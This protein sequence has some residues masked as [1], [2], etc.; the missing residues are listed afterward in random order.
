MQSPSGG[1]GWRSRVARSITSRRRRTGRLRYRILRRR[2]LAVNLCGTSRRCCWH[3]S[4]PR[5]GATAC[6][7][8]GC[9]ERHYAAP[10]F[11][12]SGQR[13]FSTQISTQRGSAVESKCHFSW[14]KAA[15]RTGWPGCDI[16]LPSWSC[17]FDSRRPLHRDVPRHRAMRSHSSAEMRAFRRSLLMRLLGYHQPLRR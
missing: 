11:M 8:S 7:A 14:S 4:T 15:Y 1:L 12:D 2:L 9:T 6:A 13:R 16:S 5:M 3:S 10:E 17:G